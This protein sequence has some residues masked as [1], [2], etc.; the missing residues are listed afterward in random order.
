MLVGGL[1]LS[2][3]AYETSSSL[4]RAQAQVRMARAMDQA[5]DRLSGRVRAVED[6]LQALR[7][8]ADRDG[9]IEVER[10]RGFLATQDLKVRMPE[11]QG[12]SYSVRVTEGG[13]EPF[14]EH[15]RHAN[16]GLGVKVWPEWSHPDSHCIL[17]VYP[18]APNARALG[19]NVAASASQRED[20]LAP[21]EEGRSRLSGPIDL[22][23][24]PGQ[25]PG[26]VLRLPIYRE[27]R[28]PETRTERQAQH[29][30][31]LSAVTLA[32]QLLSPSL[33]PLAQD[34][35]AFRLVDRPT[36]RLLL[37]QPS[38]L[39][40]PVWAWLAPA[41]K[42]HVAQMEVAGRTWVL[43]GNPQPGFLH[44]MEV[45]LP[46]LFL[47]LGLQSS[48]LI[49]RMVQVQWRKGRQAENHAQDM[50][51]RLDQ[52]ESRLRAL[53]RV[54]PDVILVLDAEGRYLEVYTG[55]IG[56]LVRPVDELIGRRLIDVLPRDLAALMQKHLEQALAEQ[57]MHSC[58][59]ELDTLKGHQYFEARVVPLEAGPQEAPAVVWV[60]RDV[61]EQRRVEQAHGELQT[62]LI[63]A[64]KLE[65]IGRL[66]GGVAHDLNNMLAPIFGYAEML[67]AELDPKD[68]R[69]GHLSCIL[70][71]AG[72]SRDLVRQLLAFARRQALDVKPVDLNSLVERFAPMLQRTVREDIHLD[73]RLTPG[74]GSLLGDAGQ[75]EQVLL[76]LVINAQ[77]AMALGGTLVIQTDRITFAEDTPQRPADLPP[78][79]YL[80]LS[81]Q[82]TGCGMDA[83][84]LSQAFEP[85][86][87][88]KEVGKGTGL[89][90]STAHGIVR[91]HGGTLQATSQVGVGTTVTML[92]P[93]AN[94]GTTVCPSTGIHMGSLAGQETVLLVEDEGEVRRLVARVLRDAGYAVLE[95]GTVLASRDAYEVMEQ[96]DLLLTDVVL[97]DGS[98]PALA[99]H[100]RAHGRGVRVL[101]MSGYTA[102]VLT[103]HG[104]L[105]PGMDFIQKPF[106]NRALLEKVREILDR[107]TV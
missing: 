46:W 50:E 32:S 94:I 106:T 55:E 74:L 8:L 83:D 62:Q 54:L 100:L 41:I 63:Q 12:I 22:V 42:P 102:E 4:R 59:Y 28:I 78:G 91:Q 73:C 5:T 66:A 99:E 61:T 92:L 9:R 44:P 1:L 16:P 72:R 105:E 80:M 48:F 65:S 51:A 52:S 85:F 14:L 34:G 37:E 70:Q 3:G 81:V 96:V 98:G 60:A 97:P 11:L 68:P 45:G 15:L 40:R 101:Y 90:L 30:G 75:I 39:P 53:T 43:E 26:L 103:P 93:E 56:N 7:G 87:T 77:D 64:Q 95:V 21:G 49:A 88:T 27:G 104:V 17:A 10:F 35:I 36:G 57:R 58:A 107:T 71:G 29:Q 76:N 89:G 38:R 24:A 47:L 25:G 33:T 69:Q 79:S 19:F 20:A 6:F 84:T 2:L 82:D 18:E 23:Q 13:R 31:T 86:F 67:Q